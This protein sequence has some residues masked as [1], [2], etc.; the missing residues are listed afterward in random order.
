MT[1]R[2][3]VFIFALVMVSLALA[4]C[5]SFD[6][7][8]IIKVKTPNAIQQTTGLPSR[9][10]LNEAQS[11]YQAWYES[12][13]RNGTQWKNY[14]ERGEEIRGLLGQLTLTALDEFGPAIAGVPVLGPALPGPGRSGG[15]VRR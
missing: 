7:G 2:K 5:A 9:T 10:S 1:A 12:V 15:P 8:D 4:A 11:E 14:I 13:Q 6:L 3:T